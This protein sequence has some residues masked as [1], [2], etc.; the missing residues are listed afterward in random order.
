MV[1][2]PMVAPWHR[3]H[4]AAG[5]PATA[6]ECMDAWHEKWVPYFGYGE[7]LRVVPEG[8]WMATETNEALG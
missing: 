6:A 4:D 1:R 2:G 8:A 5:R 7:T 3:D